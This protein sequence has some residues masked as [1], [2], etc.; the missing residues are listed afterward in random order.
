MALFLEPV[1][2]QRIWGGRNFEQF[3]YDIPTD[4]TGECWGISAHPH[5]PNRV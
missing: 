3:G 1:F 5:G 4:T 2:Q